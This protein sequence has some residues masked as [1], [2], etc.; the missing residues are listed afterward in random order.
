MS[1]YLL[2]KAGNDIFVNDRQDKTKTDLQSNELLSF[3]K[4][5]YKS[6]LN[7]DVLIS[8][9]P[10]I[11]LGCSSAT[12]LSN[13]VSDYGMHLHD[14]YNIFSIDTYDNA[15]SDFTAEDSLIVFCGVWDDINVIG[16]FANKAKS[17][18][19]NF[20]GEVY[21]VYNDLRL[22]LHDDIDASKINLITQAKSLHN[23][24]CGKFKSVQYL[25]LHLLPHFY[26]QQP[27]SDFKTFDLSISTMKFADLDAKRQQ[28]FTE[29]LTNDSIRKLFIGHYDFNISSSNYMT[30]GTVK[31]SKV[32]RYL[33]LA[34]ASYIVSEELYD[35]NNLV[36]NRVYEAILSNTGLIIDRHAYNTLSVVEPTLTKYAEVIDSPKEITQ[37]LVLSAYNKIKQLH[38]TNAVN[39]YKSC[40]MSNMSKYFN[41]YAY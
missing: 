14:M 27:I 34:Y 23:D 21:Y 26:M 32:A 40:F 4:A 11:M 25:E 22:T 12:M 18:I 19:D 9:K 6:L 39:H 2:L 3:A 1:K 28:K 35:A 31:H 17:I 36:P 37:E 41:R 5:L 24:L 29:L 7:S 8:S 15:L 10:S 30:T 16:S 20:P 33:K 13:N 38:R